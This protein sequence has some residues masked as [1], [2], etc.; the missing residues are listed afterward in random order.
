MMIVGLLLVVGGNFLR[1]WVSRAVAQG[2]REEWLAE[3][4]SELNLAFLNGRDF[5]KFRARILKGDRRLRA[6][7]HL[8][9]FLFFVGIAVFLFVPI[10]DVVKSRI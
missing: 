2:Y 10:A 9:T 1:A 8:A 4:E 5:R 6:L 3:H 7:S